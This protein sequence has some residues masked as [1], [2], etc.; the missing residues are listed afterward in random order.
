[1]DESRF[2]LINTTGND[3]VI[4]NV[5]QLYNFILI[6]S[7][8]DVEKN[9]ITSA[10]MV[11]HNKKAL[12]LMVS[13]TEL[14]FQNIFQKFYTVIMQLFFQQYIFIQPCQL[15]KISLYAI[16]DLSHQDQKLPHLL[17]GLHLE[18]WAALV[19]PKIECSNGSLVYGS[20]KDLDQLK[21]HF[22]SQVLLL[23]GYYKCLQNSFGRLNIW[24]TNPLNHFLYSTLYFTNHNLTYI[25]LT[26]LLK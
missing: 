1:M 25:C 2:V 8:L 26:F 13:R 23:C 21:R 4:Y 5:K 19:K 20:D 6:P 10:T 9:Q 14:L 12:L 11:R 22:K 17:L 16:Y 15:Q 24:N 7:E 3:S 18:F